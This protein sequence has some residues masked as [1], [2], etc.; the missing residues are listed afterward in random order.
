MILENALAKIRGKRCELKMSQ[1]ELAERIGI[2]QK[3]YS[4]KENGIHDFT[5]TELFQM[6][7]IFK[8]SISDI[9]LE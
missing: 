9:F 1:R 4:Q 8:C 5:L 2:S 7:T 6:C 3:S